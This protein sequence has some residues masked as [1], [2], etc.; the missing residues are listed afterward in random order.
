MQFNSLSISIKTTTTTT[1]T[2]I[3]NSYNH[4]NVYYNVRGCDCATAALGSNSSRV[5]KGKE[6]RSAYN[7]HA[8]QQVPEFLFVCVAHVPDIQIN[9]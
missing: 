7:V 5:T 2:T 6:K 9:V 4:H 3:H 8:G 1:T